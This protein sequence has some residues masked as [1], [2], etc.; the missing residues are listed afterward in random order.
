[1]LTF[2][3]VEDNVDDANLFAIALQLAQAEVLLRRVVNGQYA[4]D[5]VEG[6]GAF[7]D[8]LHYP[9]P[10]LVVLDWRLPRLNGAEFLRWR[11][12]SP[13]ATLPVV[14]LTGV[15]EQTEMEEARNSTAQATFAKPMSIDGLTKIAEQM[16]QLALRQH[17]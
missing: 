12:G 11:A 4:I 13:F 15:E 8:R 14:I 1:M 7:A 9:F 16:C 2:L 5:Y 6:N 17:A 10:D 3:H